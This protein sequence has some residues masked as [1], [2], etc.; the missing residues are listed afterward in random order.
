METIPTFDLPGIILMLMLGLRH[1]LDPD[2]IAIIDGMVLR[3]HEDRPAMARWVGTFF[4]FGHGLVVTVIAVVISF[5]RASISVP[6][7]VAG[8]AGWIPV[9]L[10]LL[11]GTLNLV[12]LLRGNFTSPSGWRSALIPASL[13]SSSR[14]FSVFLV[15]VLFAAVFDTATQ[16]A[17]WGNAASAAGGTAAALTV[18]GVFSLGMIMTDTLD[19]TIV[20]G[21]LSRARDRAD[22]VRY[23][24]FTGWLIVIMSYAVAGYAV[25]S[26]LA[27]SL[28]LSDMT[29]SALGLSL[30]GAVG[31]VYA[32]IHFRKSLGPASS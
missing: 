26:R 14:P 9:V 31:V 3:I 29:K 32:I 12:Q 20:N 13:R 17:A 21:I 5:V 28:E 1:G 4:A 7:S 30:L 25:I 2:H 19:S 23:R 15:G 8:I 22:I 16:A 10:L 11:V 27:P 24:V 18:G 6:A